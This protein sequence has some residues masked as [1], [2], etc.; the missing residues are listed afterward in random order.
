MPRRRRAEGGWPLEVYGAGS[1]V[2]ARHT[3]AT[4]DLYAAAGLDVP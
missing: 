2:E 1:T 3:L 4:D